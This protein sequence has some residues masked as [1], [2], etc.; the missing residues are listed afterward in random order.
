[1]LLGRNLSPCAPTPREGQVIPL[2]CSP[3]PSKNITFLRSYKQ[4]PLPAHQN[5]TRVPLLPAHQ[6]P[7]RTPLTKTHKQQLLPAHQNPARV[8]P[9]PAHQNP[10][11][12][13]P[14]LR[15]TNNNPCLLIKTQQ[16]YHPYLL[17]KTR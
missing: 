11:R 5:P 9:L 4:L 7:V 2:T 6:N 15:L 8:S 13:L 12:A 17:T 10:V 14:T 16:E 3:K 1:M